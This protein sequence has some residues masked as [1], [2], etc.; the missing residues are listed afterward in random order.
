MAGY[1]F[2]LLHALSDPECLRLARL[3]LAAQEELDAF[4][5]QAETSRGEATNNADRSLLRAMR[6]GRPYP[7]R[8]AAAV[9]AVRPH[10]ATPRGSPA[11]P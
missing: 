8:D 9:R 2:A 5:R 7:P 11:P 6:R 4:A 10:G 1:P 3:R